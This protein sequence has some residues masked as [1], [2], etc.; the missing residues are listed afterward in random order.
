[1]HRFQYAIPCDSINVDDATEDIGSINENQKKYIKEIISKV[2]NMKDNVNSKNV[3]AVPIWYDPSCISMGINPFNT[4]P[5][6]KNYGYLKKVMVHV[7]HLNFP[8][9][10]LLCTHTDCNCKAILSPKGFSNNPLARYCFGYD[11]DFYII[12][13]KYQCPNTK[14]I[15]TSSTFEL[16]DYVQRQYGVSFQKRLFI[17]IN[18]YLVIFSSVIDSNNYKHIL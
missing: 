1:M 4:K 3:G 5:D 2:Q 11:E 12:T 15:F 10:K 7:P 9:L 14:K 16:N 18:T 13:Y 6:P 17:L 8:G